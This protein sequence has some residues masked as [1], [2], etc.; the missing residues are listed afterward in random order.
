[1]NFKL[2]LTCAMMTVM[3]SF[4]HAQRP[5]GEGPLKAESRERIEAQRIAYITHRLSLSPDEAAKFWPIYNEHK[6]A[7]KDM[8][9]DIDRPDLVDVTDAEATAIIEKHLQM[10]EKRIQLRK[11]LY[12]KLKSFLSPRKILTLHSAERDFNRDLLRRA[13]EFRKN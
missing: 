4:V 6:D 9:D 11:T 7:L 10:E 8:R 12:T 13:Q 5:G 2:I 1:M 3:A